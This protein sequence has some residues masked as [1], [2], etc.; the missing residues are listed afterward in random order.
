MKKY[1]VYRHLKPCGEVFYIGMGYSINRPLSKRN[2]NKYWKNIVN[3]HEYEAEVLSTG[4]NKEVAMYIE[5]ILIGWYG[6]KDLGKG[7]L[8][9]LTDGGDGILNLCEESRLKISKAHKNKKIPESQRSKIS[10]SNK[11]T[12]R[13]L[14]QRENYSKS[15]MGEKNPMYGKKGEFSPRYNK[16]VTKETK[17]KISKSL[18]GKRIG[19]ENHNSNLVLDTSTGVIFYSAK[20]A[21]EALNIVYSTLTRQLNG[22]SKNKTNL[23]YV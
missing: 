18:K 4:L 11:G 9:N 5:S 2:R 8:V 19:Q 14:E 17:N 3:K 23:I 16:S 6:R 12:T 7:T 13:S 10:E 15:K 22:Y 20:E 1:F 21:S